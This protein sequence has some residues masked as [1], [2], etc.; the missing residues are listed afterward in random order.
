[1]RTL[2]DKK[3][4]GKTKDEQMAERKQELERRLQDVTGQLGTSKKPK[5][6]KS[7]HT[8]LYVLKFYKSSNKK[9]KSNKT[10]LKNKKN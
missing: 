5:K 8:Q 10:K 1:M 3:P 6:G 7:I 9:L 4:S 2:A